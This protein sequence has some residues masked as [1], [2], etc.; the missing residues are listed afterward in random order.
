MN[1]IKSKDVQRKIVMQILH[2]FKIT[3]EYSNIIE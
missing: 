3:V 1:I 2:I